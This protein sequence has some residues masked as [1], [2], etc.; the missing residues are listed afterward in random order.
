MKNTKGD[1]YV[2]SHAVISPDGLYRYL[3]TRCWS[4]DGPVLFWVC[5]NPSTADA[6][7]DDPTVRRLVGFS[8]RWGY[9]GLALLN[10]FA[11]RATNPKELER[12]A[13]PVGPDNDRTI[14]GCCTECPRAEVV[15]AW[16]AHGGLLMRDRQVLTLLRSETARIYTLGRTKDGH[17][18][19]PLYLSNDTALAE[20]RYVDGNC[21]ACGGKGTTPRRGTGTSLCSECEGTGEIV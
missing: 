15:L 3:L 12:A 18:K 20:A 17:P 2:G 1:A 14:L 6:E 5:L 8:K 10:L 16:G 11:L 21:P 4:H 19:H 7:T 13:D 9:G